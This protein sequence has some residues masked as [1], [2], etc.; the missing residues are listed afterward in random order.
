MIKKK[1]R[2]KKVSNIKNKEESNKTLKIDKK[3]ESEE[4]IEKLIKFKNEGAGILENYSEDEL[5]DMLLESANRYYN[6]ENDKN[7]ILSD[8]EYDILREHILKKYPKN[9]IALE[10][11]TQIKLEKDKVK[12]PYEM[13]S[14][15]KI[16]PDIDE[17]NK[18]KKI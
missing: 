2:K 14:M 1:K 17:I 10:Q 3:K 13:W 7:I 9:K 5:T 16:K 8:D 18:F 12:L 6:A 4:N 15:N 11:H